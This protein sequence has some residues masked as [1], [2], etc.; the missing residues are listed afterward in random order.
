[1]K[2]MSNIKLPF[3]ESAKRAYKGIFHC[4]TF[5][6]QRNE[7]NQKIKR[8][9]INEL[10]QSFLDS[11]IRYVCA[12]KCHILFVS[13]SISRNEFQELDLID[14]LEI[15]IKNLPPFLRRDTRW[16]AKLRVPSAM[17]EIWQCPCRPSCWNLPRLN[18]LRNLFFP[19]PSIATKLK[20]QTVSV[21]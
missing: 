21:G 1:M 5:P 4:V 12:D 3:F 8:Q 17:T 9:R 2:L 20:W 10:Y 13:Q 15:E 18:P 19:T 14:S 11:L 7:R 16:K 6:L